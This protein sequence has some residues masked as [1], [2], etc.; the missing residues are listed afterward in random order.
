M[1]I[2]LQHDRLPVP[3]PKWYI[4]DLCDIDHSHRIYRQL[5]DVDAVY[6]G[7]GRKR[8][9]MVGSGQFDHW[10]RTFGH[11]S[12]YLRPERAW[13]ANVKFM[14][15]KRPLKNYY[16]QRELSG[17]WMLNGDEREYIHRHLFH[18]FQRKPKKLWHVNATRQML[19]H[20]GIRV[21]G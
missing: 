4:L 14:Y 12:D 10:I 3:I 20:I 8:M 9:K 21:M 15:P 13:V 7:F 2:N 11:E 16:V 1:K 17:Y 6:W 19:G 5:C 18:M